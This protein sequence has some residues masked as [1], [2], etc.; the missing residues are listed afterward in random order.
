MVRTMAGGQRKGNNIK[1]LSLHRLAT[2]H[3]NITTRHVVTSRGHDSH[4]VVTFSVHWFGFYEVTVCL[5]A[6]MVL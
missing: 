1:V 2:H 5:S 4:H 6:P 3:V